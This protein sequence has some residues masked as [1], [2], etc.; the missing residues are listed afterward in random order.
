MIF[1]KNQSK[2]WRGCGGSKT[3]VKDTQVHTQSLKE[4][5]KTL[6]YCSDKMQA[7]NFQNVTVYGAPPVWTTSS[8]YH[9]QQQ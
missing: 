3:L 2:K 8:I 5:G 9:Q 1:Q 6:D 4:I 7:V